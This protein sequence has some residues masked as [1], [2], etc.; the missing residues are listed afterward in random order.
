MRLSMSK[1]VT[2]LLPLFF[3]VAGHLV[4]RLWME[5]WCGTMVTII[6]MVKLSGRW[7]WWCEREEERVG[8]K[9]GQ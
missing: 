5:D 2:F 8:G 7:G 4:R 1:T 6:M 9:A 3:P